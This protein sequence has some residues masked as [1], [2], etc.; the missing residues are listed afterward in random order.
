M[1]GPRNGR[2]ASLWGDRNVVLGQVA[3]AA[4]EPR[5]GL[6]I[7]RGRL[8]KRY[9]HLDPNEDAVL[10]AAGPAGWLLAVVDGHGGFDAARA[11][12]RT[13]ELHAPALLKRDDLEPVAAV[14]ELFV[15]ARGAVAAALGGVGPQRQASRTALSVALVTGDH[16]HGASLGDT[17]ALRLGGDEVEELG[18]A[19]PFLGP[20]TPAPRVYW[21]PFD[22]GDRLLVASDGL[23]DYIGPRW[24]EHL[25]EVAAGDPAG[26]A[27]RLVLRAFDGGAGD[28]V[29]VGVLA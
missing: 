15:A 26:A 9:R 11:A 4:L 2:S 23:T 19:G 5:A 27:H 25:R 16:A 3:T 14:H 20:G 10:A 7:S 18:S 22:Q 1:T 12:L 24:E 17:V 29:A 8:P 6:A 13:V 21:A 28:N